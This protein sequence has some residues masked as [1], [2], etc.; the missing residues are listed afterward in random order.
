MGSWAGERAL[1]S[2]WELLESEAEVLEA[3]HWRYH[4]DQRDLLIFDCVTILYCI[5]FFF[6]GVIN[7]YCI[8]YRNR[9][10]IFLELWHSETERSVSGNGNY[11]P[12]FVIK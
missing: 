6:F 4:K 8:S 10:D 7:L 2:S 5:S 12:L 1:K 3:P 9:N 11:L